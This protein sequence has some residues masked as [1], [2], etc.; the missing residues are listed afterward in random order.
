MKFAYAKMRP[1]QMAISQPSCRGLIA[2]ARKRKEAVEEAL[3]HRLGERALEK[4]ADEMPLVLGAA[5]EVVDRIGDFG[6][7]LPGIGETF[8]DFGA[9]AREHF[10]DLVGARRLG[11]DA[12][13]DGARAFDVAAVYFQ[14]QREAER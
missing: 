14:H 7:F 5:F 11:A 3:R 2:R 1:A 8:L 9:R 10:I 13:D 6:E 12:A 4:N